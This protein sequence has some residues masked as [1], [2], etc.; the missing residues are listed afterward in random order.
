MRGG[1]G[2]SIVGSFEPGVSSVESRSTLDQYAS[3]VSGRET[4]VRIY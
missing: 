3:C 2:T 1:L 4:P